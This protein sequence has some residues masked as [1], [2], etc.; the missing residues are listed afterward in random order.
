MNC[1]ESVMISMIF[2]KLQIH[3]KLKSGI[4]NMIHHFK[5]KILIISCYHDLQLFLYKKPS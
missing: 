4:V 5:V 2:V 1:G 3:R